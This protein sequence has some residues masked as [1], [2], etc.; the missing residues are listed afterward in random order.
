VRLAQIGSF[1]VPRRPVV[2]IVTR[3]RTWVTALF[4]PQRE[5]LTLHAVDAVD[6]LSRVDDEHSD[7]LANCRSTSPDAPTS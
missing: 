6:G 3:L 5:L 2:S 7:D 1:A 4:A